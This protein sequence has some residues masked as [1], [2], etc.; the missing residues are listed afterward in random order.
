MRPVRIS[1]AGDTAAPVANSIA[2][3][4][5]ELAV[6][7]RRSS[8]PATWRQMQLVRT[9]RPYSCR[10]LAR[11]LGRLLAGSPAMSGLSV[12]CPGVLPRW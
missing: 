6:Y 3:A 4:L 7:R 2:L 9:S 5:V 11:V 1:Q 12:V 10:A 8:S